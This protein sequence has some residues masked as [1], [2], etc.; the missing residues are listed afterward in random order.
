MVRVTDKTL[1]IEIPCSGKPLEE[2]SYLKEGLIEMLEFIDFE[3]YGSIAQNC[4]NQLATLLKAT[5]ITTDQALLINNAIDN[6]AVLKKSF[7]A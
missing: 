7:N 3:T 4:M 5:S 1:I 2:L 6:S